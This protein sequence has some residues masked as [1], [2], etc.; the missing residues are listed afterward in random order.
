MTDEG[1]LKLALSRL[2]ATGFIEYTGEYG[3][4]LTTFVPFAHWLKTQGLLSGRRVVSYHGMRAYY[5][6]LDDGEFAEKPGPRA[7]APNASRIW[8]SHSTYTATRQ[9]WHVMADY[10]TRYAAQ[11]RTFDRPVLFIQ[12]KF[13]VEWELGPVNFMPLKVLRTLFGLAANRFSVVYSRPRDR[14][15]TP[16]YT[17]DHNK[18]ADYPDILLA[19]SYSDVLILED[20]CD[21]TGAPYNQTKLEMLAKSRVMVSVQG[22]GAHLLACFG[23]SLLLLLHLRG[24]EYPHAY[25]AGPYKYLAEPAPV[26]LLATSFEELAAG[27]DLIASIRVDGAKLEFKDHH[28][29]TFETLRF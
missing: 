3:A 7:W 26:L 10:R 22:G 8:P 16:D 25:A 1:L 29:A 6:F 23:E 15:G 9:P 11:G 12:N 5:Y 24:D 14:P 21:Q 20:H 2:E 27:A 18:F 17:T 28:M 13:A 4:E 19:R